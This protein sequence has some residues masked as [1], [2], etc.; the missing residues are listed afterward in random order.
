MVTHPI[1]D[2]LASHLRLNVAQLVNLRL[3]CSHRLAP[4]VFNALQLGG[5]VLT[6]PR[7]FLV[8]VFLQSSDASFV[9][10]ASEYTTTPP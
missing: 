10:V 1:V 4:V 6:Q 9:A 8:S 3:Q 5:M 7:R 2:H